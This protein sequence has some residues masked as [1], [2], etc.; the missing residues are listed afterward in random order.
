[1]T[2]L[3]SLQVY[4]GTEA[5]VQAEPD[6]HQ[7]KGNGFIQEVTQKAADTM[8]RPVAMDQ[9]QSVQ[10]LKLCQCKVCIPDSLTIFYTTYTNSYM[11]H[12]VNMWER[13]RVV[14]TLLDLDTIQFMSILD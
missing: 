13:Q 11:C 12:Y 7:S 5:I 8:V 4:L 9:Q 6:V 1:M 10:E 14:V 3:K 2:V